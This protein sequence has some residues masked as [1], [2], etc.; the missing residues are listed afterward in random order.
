MPSLYELSGGK[1]V[2]YLSTFSKILS[3]GIRLGYVVGEPDMISSVVL[4]K[5]AADLQPNTLIQRAVYHYAEHGR[6]G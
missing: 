3:P 4:A 1:G 5:Q 2:V 6:F